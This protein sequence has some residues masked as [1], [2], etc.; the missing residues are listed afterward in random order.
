MPHSPD[1]KLVILDRD[2]VINYDSD[3]YIKSADEWIPIPG[4]IES[5]GRLKA[6]GYRLAV[7]SNQSGLARGYFDEADLAAMHHKLQ[8][9]ML[10]HSG[11][12]VD[13]IV[14]CPHGPDQGCQ[15][16]K[17]APGLLLEIG[18]QLESELQRVWFVGDSLKDLL[19]AEAVGACPVLVLTGKGE[20][21]LAGGGLPPGTIVFPS[22]SAAVNE[23]LSREPG[24]A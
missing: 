12:Q 4:S 8:E 10:E 15:C 1:P 9:L 21:T 22:L 23:L 11:E 7:A 20:S 18:S 13:L 17:P 3:D 24:C 6:A 16:R 5:M 19:A 14:W 2:G